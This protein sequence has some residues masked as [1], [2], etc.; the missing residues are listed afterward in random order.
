MLK[1]QTTTI[2]FEGRNF[3][4]HR[5]PAMHMSFMIRRLGGAFAPLAKV[6]TE[7]GEAGFAEGIA[8]ALQGLNDDDIAFFYT[9][10]LQHCYE[11][12]PAGNVRVLE[13]NGRYGVPDIEYDAALLN[14]LTISVL[15]FCASFLD[16]GRLKSAAEIVKALFPQN[17]RILAPSVPSRS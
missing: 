2:E 1:Q 6:I 5:L 9:I 14:L 15:V 4:L 13:S 7:R 12:L 16:V 10:A 17:L 8:G 3:E 11:V